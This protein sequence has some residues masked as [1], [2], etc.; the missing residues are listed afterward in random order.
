MQSL[1]YKTEHKA[2]KLRKSIPKKVSYQIHGLVALLNLVLPLAI[3]NNCAVSKIINT[4]PST[5]VILGA[6]E[7]NISSRHYRENWET[8]I[9]ITNLFFRLSREHHPS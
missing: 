5:T 1:S 8:I 9:S 2:N 3:K 6:L 7:K 4:H